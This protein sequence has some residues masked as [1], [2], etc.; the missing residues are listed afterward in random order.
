MGSIKNRLGDFFPAALMAAIMVGMGLLVASPS[1]GVP[2]AVCRELMAGSDQGRQALVGSCWFSPIVTLACLPFAWLLGPGLAAAAWTAWA[3]WTFALTI[4]GRI[5]ERGWAGVVLMALIALGM[6]AVGCGAN[7][8]AAVPVALAVFALRSAALWSR[9]QSLR[10]L[11]KLAAGLSGLI[12]C[13]APLFGVTVA[14][15]LAVP[16]G[17]LYG[18]D[19]RRRLP[20]VLLLGWL[21]LFYA[22]GVWLLMNKLIF[23][24]SLFFVTNLRNAGVLIWRG[25]QWVPQHPA[26]IVATAAAAYALVAGTLTHNRRAT[27]LGLLGVVF[28][29]WL[30]LLHGVSADWADTAGRAVLMTAGAMALW[31]LRHGRSETRL[32]WVIIGDLVIFA[33]IAWLGSHTAPSLVPQAV[34]VDINAQVKADVRE[35]APH[36]RVFVCGYTGLGLLADDTDGMLEPNL[37]LHIDTLRNDY[38]GQNLF[39]LVPTTNGA[40][41]TENVHSRFPDLYE[42]GGGRMLFCQDYGPWRLFEVVGAPTERQLESW[43]KQH[44]AEP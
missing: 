4:C 25:V 10:D 23:G 43:Q 40:A 38:Y 31:H 2:L 22:L 11:V 21:P 28:W 16:L 44:A 9:D 8:A 15:A 24:S 32:P 39:L 20:A 18:T 29:L 27:A 19:T 6:T 13:G 5:S 12:L 36:A 34:P 37:D 14:L 7:P 1:G 33:A 41:A 26:D 3:A 42:A 35:R 17:A 30:A